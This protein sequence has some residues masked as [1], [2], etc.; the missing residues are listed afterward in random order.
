MKNVQRWF[1]HVDRLP[2]ILTAARIFDPFLP[3][4]LE[5]LDAR[6]IN[7]PMDARLPN[8]L[9]V[10]LTE[11]EDV[12]ILWHIFVRRCYGVS[13]RDSVILD[14]GANVGFFALYAATNAPGARIYSVEPFPSTFQRLTNHLEWNSL[15]ARVTALNCAI[16]SSEGKRFIAGENVPAGQRRLLVDQSEHARPEVEVP[17]RTLESILDGYN[18]HSVDLAKVDIEGSEY[19]VLLSTPPAILRRISRMDLEIHNNVTAQGRNSEE[20]IAHL[21]SAGMAL[22]SIETDAQGFSQACFTRQN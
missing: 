4:T 9:R 3:I 1:R 16:A 21:R 19:E 18:L 13:G 7:Y 11:R 5:Y 17:C 10:R 15:T 6:P 2:E 22:S 12:K 8:G 20:L 14:L